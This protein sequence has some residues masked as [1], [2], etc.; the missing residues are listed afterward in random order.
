MPSGWETSGINWSDIRSNRTEAIVYHLHKAL[1]ERYYNYYLSSSARWNASVIRY[2]LPI[3]PTLKNF[4]LR[5]D[6]AMYE[7]RSILRRLYA[8]DD[9]YDIK[10]G[11]YTSYSVATRCLFSKGYNPVI[12]PTYNVINSPDPSDPRYQ[13]LSSTQFSEYLGGL[14]P[15]DIS[16]GGELESIA[17][18]DLGFIRNLDYNRRI[19]IQDLTKVYNILSTQQDCLCD[20][21]RKSNTTGSTQYRMSALGGYG[22]GVD[23]MANFDNSTVGQASRASGNTASPLI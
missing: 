7:I 5:T 2:Y 6:E 1:Y 8:V 22:L 3:R 17:Q 20:T 10:E 9:E 11:D 16:E 21:T 19:D 13:N 4:R 23:F 14:K 18:G 12:K 15:L